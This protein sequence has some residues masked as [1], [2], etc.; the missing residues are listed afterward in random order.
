MARPSVKLPERAQAD[1]RLL[2]GTSVE[3]V[4]SYFATAYSLGW[5][6]AAL[7]DALGLSRQRVHQRAARGDL[8]HHALPSIP[9]PPEREAPSESPALTR[10]EIDRLRE[11]HVLA[12][13]LRSN[14]LSDDPRRLA[15]EELSSYIDKLTQ[16]GI[17]Y[18]QVGDAMGIHM[19]TVRDRLKRHG[20]RKANPALKL[21]R[22]ASSSPTDPN[23][24]I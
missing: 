3:L 10:D 17:T 1:L 6:Y 9:R 8:D 19:S 18:R 2:A 14:A 11:L 22:G 7:G 13:Q 12:H 21:Y 20:H 15:S 23:R 24:R 5:S 16:R 4:D